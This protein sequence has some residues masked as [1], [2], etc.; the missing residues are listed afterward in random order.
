[1]SRDSFLTMVLVETARLMILT[2]IL[3]SI[4][5]VGLRLASM[6]PSGKGYNDTPPFRGWLW[7]G[8]VGIDLGLLLK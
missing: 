8:F 2:D 7:P 6:L 1:M 3:L 4:W 5:C